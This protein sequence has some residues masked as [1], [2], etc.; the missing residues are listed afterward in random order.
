MTRY[1]V[2]R[3]VEVI[4]SRGMIVSTAS[5]FRTTLAGLS[6]EIAERQAPSGCGFL[7][8]YV[9][10]MI[11]LTLTIQGL[12]LD[13]IWMGRLRRKARRLRIVRVDIILSLRLN[14]EGLTAFEVTIIRISASTSTY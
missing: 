9:F 6:I 8:L 12:F 13:R 5:V 1:L 14:V 11:L 3:T 2:R 10:R 7:W 4:L